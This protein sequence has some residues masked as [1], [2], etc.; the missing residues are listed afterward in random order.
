M[1]FAVTDGRAVTHRMP[2]PCVVA[3][4]SHYI[5]CHDI[6]DD[7][8]RS[9]T[10]PGA[11]AA[12]FPASC[13]SQTLRCWSAARSCAPASRVPHV[14]PERKCGQARGPGLEREASG[15]HSLTLTVVGKRASMAA[16]L[17]HELVPAV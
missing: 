12:S 6:T 4:L 14:C 13:V 5:S 3:N 8:R 15:L 10:K 2:R 11:V 17:R 1:S 16:G 9:L 7:G